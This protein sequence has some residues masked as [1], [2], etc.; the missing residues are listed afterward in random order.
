MENFDINAFL[1]D[2]QEA[3]MPEVTTVTETKGSKGVAKFL[4][5]LGIGIGVTKLVDFALKTRREW[6]EQRLNEIRE[7]LNNGE[8]FEKAAAE[9]NDTNDETEDETETDDE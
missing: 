3:E 5:G 7:R 4:L 6:V 1:A 9:Q 8:T 2:A